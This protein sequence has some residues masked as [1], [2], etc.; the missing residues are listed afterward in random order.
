MRVQVEKA[1]RIALLRRGVEVWNDFRRGHPAYIVLNCTSLP[2]AELQHIDLHCVL[3][4]QS[5]LRR[6]NLNCAS[7]ERS[8]LRSSDFRGSDLRQANLDGADLCRADLSDAD[9][10]EASLAS[11]FLKRTD[12]T[13]ADLS[14]AR[15]L[16]FEQ[17]CDAHG[18]DR[19]KLPRG[20]ERPATWATTLQVHRALG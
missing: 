3:L 2:G 20:M 19:T 13:G 4:M 7:F 15:G 16:T 14:T 6:A 12:L 1:G 17:I 8:I 18:D 10:R 9:L 11:A 5:D